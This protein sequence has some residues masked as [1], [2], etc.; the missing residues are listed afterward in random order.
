MD[1]KYNPANI[2]S[3]IYNKWLE[4]GYFKARVNPDKPKYSIVLPP[5]NVTSKLHM[6][7]AYN[8]T[9]Q[10]AL[11]RFKRMQGF[12]ALFLPGKDHAAIATEAKVVA[13]LAEEGLTKEQIGR[14]AFFERMEEWYEKYGNIIV[15]QYKK[16]GASCD[17]DRLAFTLDEQRSKAVKHVFV[18]LFEKG[19]IYKGSRI[20][21]W[22]P[23]CKTSISDIEVVYK[24]SA[25][26]I[27]YIKYPITGTN[28][29]VTIAT[30][31]PE[32]ML[33]DT[34]V[35]VNPSD[36]RYKHLVGKTLTLPLVN[37]QIPVVAD[38]YV[39]ADFGTGA[40]KIT[41]A[42]D[43]NDF[44]VG[45]RHNLEVIRVIDDEAKMNELAGKYQGLDRMEARKAMIE[46]L[47]KQGLLEKI[48]DHPNKTTHCDRCGTLIEPV[49]SKQWFVKMEELAKPAI[50]V[51]KE[52]KVK[53][54]PKRF[55]KSYL[56]WM[57]NI[58]DWC[59]SRQLWTGHR[60]PVYT[61]EDCGEVF[62]S[63]TEVKVC[64]K[65]GKS[66]VVQETDV[67][68][69]WFSSALWPFS[70]LGFPDKTEDL[71]YFYPT[72]VL[73]TAYEI[74]NLWVAR[75]IF[76]GLEFMDDI[77]FEDVVINGM[78]KDEHGRKMSKNWGNG[79][80]PL[81]VI[82]KYGTDSMRFYLLNCASMGQDTRYKEADIISA[83]NFINKLWNASSFVL[84]NSK[85]IKIKDVKDVNLSLEDKWILHEYN[86][87]VSRY[88]KFLDKYEFNLATEEIY[89]FAWNKFCDWYIEI[90]KTALYS[91]SDA[92]KQKTVS[93]LMHVL[94]GILKLLHPI[95]P[96]VTEEIYLSLPE[97]SESIMI[98]K[99]P[100][101]DKD[102]EFAADKKKF[103]EVMSIVRKIR[104]VRSEL[105]VADNK[106]IK[107]LILPTKNGLETIGKSL[108]VVAKMA[109]A[110][111]VTLLNEELKEENVSVIVSP[112][113][114]VYL[115][116][117]GMV[118]AT[119]EKERLAKLL[120]ATE[121][122]ITRSEK[123]LSNK[124]F[125]AN[126]PEKLIEAEKSKLAKNKKLKQDIEKS[127][128][129]L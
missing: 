99:F 34:A 51:V 108:D 121:F 69:T 125:V 90:S 11:I 77:P 49:I 48:E 23:S 102:L 4:K 18:K 37:K 120:N 104:N 98:S 116:T 91:D 42:H 17:W 105:N 96:F 46:D 27:W 38:D 12:E 53:F 8:G 59:I 74:I 56:H 65:C 129:S 1:K 119:K 94:K 58:Q 93:V 20:I 43:P 25:S 39:A 88:I 5:P 60:M 75:M 95:A 10:D 115:P 128:Q 19:Y 84:Q 32:T 44:E 124:G 41:P 24:E 6:G 22:C 107:V 15:E 16:M 35:A 3:D 101:F 14:E 72:N 55:E 106:K 76:T 63:E 73:V 62:A 64:K 54:H 81:E 89:D 113:A 45:L 127:L 7:H 29:F 112:I 31:R 26:K 2:E 92:E 28:E 21:N 30:T 100:E 13:A 9:I 126:A 114:K 33:G 50:K 110:N 61:C 86:K 109:M 85:D 66:K 80:D 47:E 70:T 103:E 117:N 118:D 78:V 68:D 111:E 71:K 36:E 57:E 79:V 123:M 87:T 67:L 97:A 83:G 122:E 40:V 52:G 82:E